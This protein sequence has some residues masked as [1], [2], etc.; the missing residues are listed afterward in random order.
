MTDGERKINRQAAR[1][2]KVTVLAFGLFLHRMG[3]QV[4]Q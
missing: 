3:L 2:A 4:F 1:R